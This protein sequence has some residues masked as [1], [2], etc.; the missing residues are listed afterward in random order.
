MV[1]RR[2][3]RRSVTSARVPGSRELE[4]SALPY[5]PAVAVVL[6]EGRVIM[7]VPLDRTRQDIPLDGHACSE[8]QHRERKED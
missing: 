8:H 5:V 7:D 6:D 4:G 1:S 2:R 3:S